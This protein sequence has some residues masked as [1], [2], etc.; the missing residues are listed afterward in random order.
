MG[1]LRGTVYASTKSGYEISGFEWAM[2]YPL[3]FDSKEI[4]QACSESLVKAFESE[5]R[6]EL[7]EKLFD[8]TQP[9]KTELAAAQATIQA[10]QAEIEKLRKLCMNTMMAGSM[11][12]YPPDLFEILKEKSETIG[13]SGGV[14]SDTIEEYLEN[15]GSSAR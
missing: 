11:S 14:I 6:Y 7:H 13:L 12:H 5:L 15:I 10:Q 9:L 4:A 1:L 8:A 2:G 3:T